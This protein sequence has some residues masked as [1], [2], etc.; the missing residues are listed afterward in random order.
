MILEVSTTMPRQEEREPFRVVLV[1]GERERS[2]EI[3]AF[4]GRTGGR[5]RKDKNCANRSG[6]EPERRVC[7]QR[8]NRCPNSLSG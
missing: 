8:D 4:H 3:G 1:D 7:K 6:L 2:H 5:V